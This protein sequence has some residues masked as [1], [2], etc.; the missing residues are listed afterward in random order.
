MEAKA[1]S[2]FARYSP[3]KTGQVL[4]LIRSKSVKDALDALSVIVKGSKELVAKTLKS[5]MAN[6]PK[7]SAPEKVFVKE[8]YVGRG[9]Y[10]RRFRAGPRGRAMPY[11]RK[12]CH[13]T[14]VLSD[15]RDEKRSKVKG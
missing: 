13:L 2:R 15:E 1:I 4:S 9:I 14:I 11:G 8:A 10:L 7:G 5:A 6:M 12:T 3:R